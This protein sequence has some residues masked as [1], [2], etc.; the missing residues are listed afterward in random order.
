MR[1]LVP[2]HV[3]RAEAEEAEKTVGGRELL[4]DRRRRQLPDLSQVAAPVAD[5]E[6]AGVGVLER[7][8]EVEL[9]GLEPLEEVE[10]APTVG[11]P[12]VLRERL[13][14]EP[15]LVGGGYTVD[16]R[17]L[18]IGSGFPPLSPILLAVIGSPSRHS[19][20]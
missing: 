9:G 10:G 11:A 12:G 3:R 7:T 8:L 19:F 20:R 5:G 14:C 1:R 4:V 13:A 16:G 2:R 18:V 17:L 6:V 15:L